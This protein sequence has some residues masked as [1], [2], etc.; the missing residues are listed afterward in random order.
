MRWRPIAVAGNITSHLF[1]AKPISIDFMTPNPFRKKKRSR[2]VLEAA[3][4]AVQH[5]LI[6]L[7]KSEQIHGQGQSHRKGQQI[8]HPVLL[9][10]HGPVVEGG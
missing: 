6:S 8:I 4:Y 1:P 2:A 5:D 7:K 9:H 3:I 10:L